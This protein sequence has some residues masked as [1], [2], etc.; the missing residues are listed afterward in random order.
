MSI[1]D[2]LERTLRDLHVLVSR[3]EKITGR[4]DKVI[5]DKKVAVALLNHL[6][7]VIYEMM[8]EYE[9]TEHS[10]HQAEIEAKKRA[11]RIIKDA[12]RQAEDIYAASVI[13]TDDALEKL[14]EIIDETNGS[15]RKLMGKINESFREEKKTVKENQIELKI[16]LE[17]LRDTAKYIRIIEEKNKEVLKEKAIPDEERKRR[18][19]DKERLEKIL[20]E[21]D[22]EGEHKESEA[23]KEQEIQKKTSRERKEEI[24][25]NPSESQHFTPLNLEIKVNEDF[26]R[27]QGMTVDG[28]VTPETEVTYSKP[29]IKIN[30]EYFKKT[31]IPLEDVKEEFAEEIPEISL[32]IEEQEKL[33]QELDLEYFNW[34]EEEEP[35]RNSKKKSK[36]FPFGRWEK[37]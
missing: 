36:L 7:T 4:E 27:R 34:K 19:M 26:L 2:K 18:K 6:N 16:Q 35:A 32:S 33:K 20:A 15:M 37:F 10:R 11:E 14:Q 31:G 30:E 1:Q 28:G 17:D 5:I 12:D 23:T 9:A 13:Y 21:A 29:E 8:D 3:G 24:W 25:K 22:E